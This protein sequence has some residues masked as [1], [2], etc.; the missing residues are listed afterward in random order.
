MHSLL[1]GPYRAIFNRM[2][3]VIRDCFGLVLLRSVIG[4]KLAPLSQPIGSDM[5]TRLFPRLRQLG[6]FHSA[7]SLVLKV[8]S[9]YSDRPL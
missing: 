7:F 5:V 6:G 3:I 1:L 2:S 4:K 9:S 8:I